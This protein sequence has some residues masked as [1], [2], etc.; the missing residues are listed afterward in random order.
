MNQDIINLAKK[1]IEIE[2]EGLKQVEDS[3]NDVFD[4]IVVL[5]MECTGKI[6]MTGMGKSG[7]I[8]RKISATLSSLGTASVFLH[9]AEAA[10]GDLG[11]VEEQDVVIMV[12]NSGETDEIIQ[13]IPSL[14]KIGCKL[15]AIV[16]RKESTLSK[17]S[18][19]EW[20]IPVEKEACI[21]NMAPTTSTTSVLAAGDA[22]AVVLSKLKNIKKEDFAVYHPKGTLGRRLLTTVEDIKTQADNLVIEKECKLQEALFTITQNRMGA[23]CV[24]D[25]RENL[26]GLI[27][28]GDIRRCI[29]KDI[30]SL[31]Y[32]VE[33]VMTKNPIVVKNDI[34]VVDIYK[35]MK[36]KKIS[37]VPVLSDDNKVLGMI[38]LYNILDA[39]IV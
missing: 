9:P 31:E 23:V 27:S 38:T 20:F 39:G 21:L 13:L 15:V 8:A 22:L 10:H 34:L 19:I 14:H 33:K 26:L 18:D 11:M 17:Y 6:I 36:N 4:S 24:T 30:T 12:S 35:I 1:V 32:P 5:C 16:C 29:E 7:H 2:I 37:V 25:N 28:D 3:V